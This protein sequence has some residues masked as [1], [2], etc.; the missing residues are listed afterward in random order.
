[1]YKENK[2]RLQALKEALQ[3][4]LKEQDYH[5]FLYEELH[6][7]QLK[8]GEQ[9]E[10]ESVHEQLSNVE[11]IRENLINRLPLPTTNSMGWCCNSTNLNCFAENR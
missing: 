3:T 11:F 9:Q 7:A 8:A 2:S 6:S 4:N 10:L 1:V 5:N